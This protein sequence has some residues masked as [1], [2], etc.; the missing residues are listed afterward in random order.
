MLVCHQ[1]ARLC[2]STPVD[3]TLDSH[4]SASWVSAIFPTNS[5]ISSAG[6]RRRASI[7]LHTCCRAFA[8]YQDWSRERGEHGYMHMYFVAPV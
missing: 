4:Y 6:K 1:C 7:D 8:L 2:L 5:G 3:A